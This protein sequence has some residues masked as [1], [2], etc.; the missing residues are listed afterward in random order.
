MAQGA[1]STPEARSAQLMTYDLTRASAG[2]SEALASVSAYG[3]AHQH[4]D[5]GG[6]APHRSCFAGPGHN[7]Q[8]RV[9]QRRGATLICLSC[10][11]LGLSL[12]R[13]GQREVIAPGHAVRRR[14]CP[15]KTVNIGHATHSPTRLTGEG[16][17]PLTSTR[18]PR[19][20]AE[21]P[22]V[23]GSRAPQRLREGRCAFRVG[24]ELSAQS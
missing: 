1:R 16:C 19:I 2:R 11:C 23:R 12:S 18:L 17:R 20:L 5:E 8:R 9:W 24:S 3:W 14:S 22:T 21:K 6:P 7:D 15:D 4:R 10:D 13:A